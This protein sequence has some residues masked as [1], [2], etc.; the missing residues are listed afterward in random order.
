M[1]VWHGSTS[2]FVIYGLVWGAGAS[3]N[4]LWQVFMTKQ[5]GKKRYKTVGDSFAYSSVARGLLFAFFALS[6]TALWVNMHQLS[7]LQHRLGI[8]GLTLALIGTAVVATVGGILVNRA[9]RVLVALAP[10]LQGLTAIGVAARNVV[11]ASEV[12]LIF[13]V[14]SFFHKAPEFVYKAF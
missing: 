13:A 1:G 9:V 4:K 3:L 8:A 14:S 12:L 2:V 7:L 5:L 10:R 6:V 11:L